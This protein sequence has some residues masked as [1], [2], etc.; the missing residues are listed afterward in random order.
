MTDYKCDTT[1]TTTTDQVDSPLDQWYKK[2]GLLPP[3]GASEAA[4]GGTVTLKQTAFEEIWKDTE[5]NNKRA[6]NV[7]E[8]KVNVQDAFGDLIQWHTDAIIKTMKRS[9]TDG[10]HV[11][12]DFEEL[13][14]YLK[15]YGAIEGSNEELEGQFD[16]IRIE[17]GRIED[18]ACSVGSVIDDAAH[19]LSNAQD[20]AS[21]L[22]GEV[23]G[24]R[25]TV[26]Q[27]EVK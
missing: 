12:A 1:T 11:S 20:E 6:M 14:E 8:M 25:Y 22:A 19:E 5:T 3:T 15:E 2:H 27:M 4:A 17:L 21:T 16:E 18:M 26:D 9:E 13:V 23:E 10:L 7:A 24:L